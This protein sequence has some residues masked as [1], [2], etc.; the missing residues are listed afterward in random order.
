MITF[1]Y[2]NFWRGCSTFVFFTFIFLT[3]EF[4]AFVFL[5]FVFSTFEFSAFVF[6]TFVI[7]TFVFLTFVFLTLIFV[8]YL[9]DVDKTSTLPTKKSL[10]F[11]GRTLMLLL[12]NPVK[13]P[14]LVTSRKKIINSSF[15]LLAKQWWSFSIKK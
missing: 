15:G 11:H 12:F 7:S 14:L 1:T 8:A 9:F 5:T 13:S 10:N 3:F 6:L 2:D 4:S